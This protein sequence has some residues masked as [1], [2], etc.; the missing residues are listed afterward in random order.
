[1]VLRLASHLGEISKVMSPGFKT[2]KPLKSKNQIKRK[3][4]KSRVSQTYPP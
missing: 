4:A 2:T 3:W 1:M